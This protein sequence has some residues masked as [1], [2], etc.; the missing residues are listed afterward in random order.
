VLKK[1]AVTGLP[2]GREFSA[3]VVTVAS[4]VLVGPVAVTA[5]VTAGPVAVIVVS[6]AV[7]SGGGSVGRG[8]VLVDVAAKIAV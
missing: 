2:L 7:V 3:P 5:G 8:V 4:G 6:V 1:A